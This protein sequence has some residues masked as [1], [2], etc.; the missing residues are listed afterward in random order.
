MS[1]FARS[2]EYLGRG[3]AFPL[4][5]DARGGLA[6]TGGERDIEQAIRIILGT[7]PGERRMR[8]EFG[9]RIHEL[10]F[11]PRDAT[12][13][14]LAVHYVETALAR[15]EPRIETREVKV[16]TDQVQDGALLIEIRY[17]IKDTHDE[18][19]IIYPLYLTA[20]GAGE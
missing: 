15:W 16:S 11:A 3:L 20:E 2:K 19:S 4:Q 5:V 18:R 8:P 6:L 14:A 7:A 12:T 13:R 17:E 10:V 9:C 1:D